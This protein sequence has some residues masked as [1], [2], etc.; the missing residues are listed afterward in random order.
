MRTNLMHQLGVDLRF[1]AQP[2]QPDNQ[3]FTI[4]FPMRHGPPIPEQFNV[5]EKQQLYV[6]EVQ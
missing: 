1:L 5:S 4:A 6:W 2:R 3:L